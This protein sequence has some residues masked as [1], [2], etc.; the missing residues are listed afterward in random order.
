MRVRDLMNSDIVTLRRET[1]LTEICAVMLQY[2]QN[3]FPVV[4]GEYELVGMLYEENILKPLFEQFRKKSGD[5]PNYADFKSLMMN[6]EF[7]GVRADQMMSPDEAGVALDLDIVRAGAIMSA[8][9]VRHLAVI[10]DQRVVGMIS[11]SAIFL[12]LMQLAGQRPQ[13]Q[14]GLKPS[15]KPLVVSKAADFEKKT[16][17]GE[18]RKFERLKTTIKVA[19]KL[20]DAEGKTLQGTGRFCLC[21]NVSLGGMLLEIDEPLPLRHLIVMAFEIPG[22]GVPIKRLARVSRVLPG[23]TSGHHRTGIMFLA[24]SV[25][26]TKA[27]QQLLITLKAN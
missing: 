7:S 21:L 15:E 4:N 26:E 19:Y 13:G 18:R 2:N 27:M 9:K 22:S 10:A 23:E 8:R 17:V 11:D 6:S 24:L 12:Q 3:D 16:P 14:A 25:E 1:E 5:V 20:A